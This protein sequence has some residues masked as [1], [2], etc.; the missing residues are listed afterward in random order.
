MRFCSSI[1]EKTCWFYQCFT[2]TFRTWGLTT[3][4]FQGS[5]NRP[6]NG[7]AHGAP[8]SS[9]QARSTSWGL[10]TRNFQGAQNRSPNGP[11]HG[12]PTPSPVRAFPLQM[13]LCMV[14]DMRVGPSR[15]RLR[16]LSILGKN[17]SGPPGSPVGVRQKTATPVRLS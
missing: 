13:L 17:P 2:N 6:P 1:N 4:S 5:Q 9:G 7:P 10:T 11:A 12:A 15:R 8:N 3:R 16:T 14:L